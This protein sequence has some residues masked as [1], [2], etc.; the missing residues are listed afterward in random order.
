MFRDMY[1]DDYFRENIEEAK[2]L[3]AE[4]L[5]EEGLSQ[6]PET[7]LIYNTSEGHKAIA[8]AIVDQWRKALG[9][10]V[11]VANMEWGTFLETRSAQQFDIA[12]AGWGADFNHAINFTYDLIHS[13]SGNNDGRYNNPEVDRHLDQALATNND[14]EAVNHIAQAEKIAIA[15]DMA[16]LPIY[17]YTTV[18]M[19]KPGF[20]DVV[21]DFSGNLYWI[22]GDKQ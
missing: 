5:Q 16:V 10:E 21:S 4:G 3:L 15:D 2:K 11:K 8:E 9:I 22:F 6:F 7:T 20:V 19:V 12:R 17:Y 1:P 13:T 14:Q 18:T